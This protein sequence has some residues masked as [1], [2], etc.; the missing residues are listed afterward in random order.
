MVKQRQIVRMLLCVLLLIAGLMMFLNGAN[1]QMRTRSNEE[2]DYS[3]LMLWCGTSLVAAGCSLPFLRLPFVALISAVAPFAA[4]WALAVLFWL[5]LP[6]LS[7]F[8]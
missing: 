4:F 7:L 3:L 2:D 1:F 8:K 6:I 5:V